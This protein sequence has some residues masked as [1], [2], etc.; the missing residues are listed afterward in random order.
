MATFRSA[1]LAPVL[2]LVAIS[3]CGA[4]A[5]NSATSPHAT[6]HAKQHGSTAEIAESTAPA[7]NAEPTVAAGCTPSCAK[8]I[9]EAERR[10][11]QADAMKNEADVY[12]GFA[13]RAGEAFVKA[14]RG[15]L[16]EVP[17]GTDLVCKGGRAVVSNMVR[18]FA[19]SDSDD[20]II[21]ANLVALDPRWTAAGTAGGD[22]RSALRSAADRAEQ[23]AAKN[24]KA[25][26]AAERIDAAA[27]ARLALGDARGAGRDAALYRQ[28]WPQNKEEALLLSAAIAGQHNDRSDFAAALASLGQA[29]G[30]KDDPRACVVWHAEHGRALA[31][32]KRN[33]QARAELDAVVASWPTDHQAA[34]KLAGPMAP[35]PMPDREGVVDAVASALFARAENKRLAAEALAPPRFAGPATTTGFSQFVSTR[36]AEWA[37][38]KQPMV[39]DAVAAYQQIASTKPA[40]SRRWLTI[41]AA[42]T[43]QLFASYI[44]QFR[45][46]PV[47]PAVASDPQA[48]Q[49]YDKAVQASIEPVI[50]AARSAFAACLDRAKRFHVE[51]DDTRA[52]QAWI[53]KNAR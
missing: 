30:P 45:A 12:P 10:L 43:G 34:I 13:A 37:G 50:E 6:E 19:P 5:P 8:L 21:F 46:I 44:G 48:R 17:D 42:R 33:D 35:R 7:G 31:G 9:D 23:T 32:S 4:G 26:R 25:D 14:W 29:P 18:A 27:Y 20:G 40:A 24:A 3:G 36:V 47:P 28:K 49:A 41:A 16:L 53:D 2:G 51:S 39:Q 11:D 52:C 22:P 1:R 38:K 15:C